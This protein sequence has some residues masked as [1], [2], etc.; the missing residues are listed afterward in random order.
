M[1]W[2]PRTNDNFR[3]RKSSQTIFIAN[4]KR[5]LTIT[6]HCCF[7]IQKCCCMWSWNRF[8]KRAQQVDSFRLRM[9]RGPVW[10]KIVCW[11]KFHVVEEFYKWHW[12]F[13]SWKFVMWCWQG[14]IYCLCLDFF[15]IFMIYIGYMF[16][17][18]CM[19]LCSWETLEGVPENT[20]I[21]PIWVIENPPGKRWLLL[22]TV[23]S[24]IRDE[25]QKSNLGKQCL[26]VLYE[27]IDSGWNLRCT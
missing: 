8:C 13:Y 23:Y 10:Q 24:I 2:R 5:Q 14:I 4:K 3:K 16:L 21:K 9:F 19:I 25:C 18:L 20:M 6:I 7:F 17:L 26:D 12:F 11:R 15:I 22:R 27:K 1:R